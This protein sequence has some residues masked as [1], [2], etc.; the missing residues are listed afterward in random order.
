MYTIWRKKSELCE[1]N[2]ELSDINILRGKVWI[3]SY[4]LLIARI[5]SKRQDINSQF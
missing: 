2:A 5:H 3:V 1:I 4:E